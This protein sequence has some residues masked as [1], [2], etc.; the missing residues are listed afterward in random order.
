MQ[1]AKEK[2][3]DENVNRLALRVIRGELLERERDSFGI[4]Y[5]VYLLS[6]VKIKRVI[7][8]KRES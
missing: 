6:I 7:E 2:N 8:R 5:T 3:K 4:L 1:G